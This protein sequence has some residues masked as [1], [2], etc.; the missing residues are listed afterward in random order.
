ME[1]NEVVVKVKI[2]K[3]RK[4]G[5]RRKVKIEKQGK[6]GKVEKIKRQKNKYI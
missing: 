3:R 1:V 4:Q 5:K 2:E 6:Q